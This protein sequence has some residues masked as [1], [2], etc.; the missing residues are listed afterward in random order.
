[1]F[2]ESHVSLS[3]AALGLN[4][5]ASVALVQWLCLVILAQ[6][7]RYVSRELLGE[8]L[9]WEITWLVGAWEGSGGGGLGENP[10]ESAQHTHPLT[11][12]DLSTSV[13]SKDRIT[14][15]K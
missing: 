12:S 10:P 5:G 2:I 15:S 6:G 13:P 11:S 1:M 3:M 7:L 8:W 4:S 14:I 9:I